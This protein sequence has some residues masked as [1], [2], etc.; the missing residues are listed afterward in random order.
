MWTQALAG[1]AGW[2]PGQLRCEYRENPLGIDSFKPRLGW[3]I[4]NPASENSS[5]VVE[6]GVSQTAY[7]VLV[8]SDAQLLAR[9]QGDLWDSG[10]VDGDRSIQ[11]EY[12]GKPLESRMHCHWK[13]RVWTATAD[14]RAARSDWSEP[15]HW[16]MGLLQADDWT[17]KWIKPQGNQT[18]PWMRK[19]FKLDAK[20]ARATAFV[21]VKGYCELYVNGKKVGDDVLS[22]AVTVYQKRTRYNT[23]DISKYLK[24]G[25]NCV[26][27]WMGLGLWYRRGEANPDPV[28]L[29]RIQLDMTVDGKQVAVG[30]DSSW[31]WMASTHTEHW[32]DW[33]ANGREEIDA[34]GDVPDWS[35]AGC[36]SGKWQPVEEHSERSGVATA[37]SCPPNRITKVIPLVTS[38]PLNETTYEL[39]FGTNLNGWLR[40]PLP[41][42]KAG[43]KVVLHFADKRFQTPGGDSTPA[44]HVGVF[45]PGVK[46]FQ[47]SKGP[48]AY[49]THTQKAEFISAGKPGEIFI[50]KFNYFSFRYAIVEGMRAKPAAEGVEALMIESDMKPAGAFECSNELLNQIHQVNVWTVRCMNLGGY[51]VDC[52]HRERMG[53]GADGQTSLVTQIMNLD[54][55]AFYAKWAQD[56]LDI[57][58]PAT[59]KTGN[60]APKNDDPACWFLWGGMIDV[61][62][63]KA[64]LYYGDKRLLE[65]A[66]DSMVLYVT[67]YVDSFYPDGGIGQ[68]GGEGGSDWAAPRIGMSAPPGT[69]LF[70][71]CYRVYLFDLLAKT[72]DAL[73]K[74]QDAEQFRGRMKT[75]R[76]LI[77]AKY[78][79]PD[80]KFYES[81]RQ[82]DQAMPLLTGVVPDD[83]RATVESSLEEIIMGKNQGNLD[84]GMLGTLFLFE[85][86][87]DAGRNDLAYTMATRKTFPGWGYLLSLGMTTFGEEWNGHW[88]QIHGCYLNPSGWMY[89]GLA[90]ILPDE[91]GPAFKKIVIKPSVV[92]DLTWVKASH[93]SMHGRIISNWKREGTTLTMDVTIPCNAT[94]TIHVPAKNAAGVSESGGPASKAKGVKF[95]RMERGAAVYQV[96]SGRY[97]FTSPGLPEIPKPPKVEI[98]KA[99]YGEIS[100]GAVVD[101]TEKVRDL[102]EAGALAIEASNAHFSDPAPGRPKQLEVEYRVNDGKV[103]SGRAKETERVTLGG[104]GK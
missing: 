78:F 8:A 92:G 63:W 57:Q 51:V 47:S 104:A 19:E 42:M 85:S 13:V 59:G 37:Q 28:P 95:L 90:G 27:A 21:N 44:G 71:N 97:L 72:A 75:L 87:R 6:R 61:M 98:I 36:T 53:Y 1:P 81:G 56:W 67:R 14:G 45:G 89:Q 100:G 77:H 23:Y 12:A 69:P 9:D 7:Q 66:Y 50:P 39:D 32:W 96:G 5:G 29:A 60:F 38:T 25:E 15:G 35:V 16:S 54:S 102:V 84:T 11:I 103:T 101:V 93:D 41:Q 80:G 86:L 74:T 83:L 4:G 55:A 17:A 68:N 49:Q 33:N 20:P 64:Y 10:K 43:E 99:T 34:R 22:P 30:T 62:P 48:V 58:D 2:V 76:E 24:E 91:S 65:K 31:T 52:P 70:V 82:L 73:G 18:S 46:T 94:A 88:S 26:G 79:K 40:L 3:V